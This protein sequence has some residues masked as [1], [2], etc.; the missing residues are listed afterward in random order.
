MSEQ[1]LTRHFNW[2]ILKDIYLWSAIFHLDDS[3]TFEFAEEAVYCNTVIFM[4]LRTHCVE[5]KTVCWCL[6]QT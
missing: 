3:F 6:V 1:Q 4:M 2:D 5:R